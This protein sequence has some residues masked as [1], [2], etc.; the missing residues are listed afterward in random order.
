MFR[1][2][3]IRVR[4]GPDRF[5][6]ADFAVFLSEPADFIPEF[7]PYA[8]VEIVSPDDRF[9]ELMTKLADYE[10]AGVEF[11]YVADPPAR[12]L[13]RYRQGDLWAV[14]ALELDAQAVRIPAAP[15][16]L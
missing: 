9:E 6:V 7:A 8:V 15:L 4:V 3:E 14:G 13:S 5:R 12:K 10:Q 1:A 11:I 2:T 16:F